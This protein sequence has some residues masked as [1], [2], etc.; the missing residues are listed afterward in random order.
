LVVIVPHVSPL[1]PAPVTLHVTLV[2][3]VPVTVAV[4]CCCASVTTCAVV[5]ET[6]T[7]TGGSTVT[8]AVA[9]FDVSAT[10]VAVTFTCGGLGIVAGA[11]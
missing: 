3:V 9:D 4:N 2:L 11:V 10:E 6:V 8:T 5:G 1:Q 7:T